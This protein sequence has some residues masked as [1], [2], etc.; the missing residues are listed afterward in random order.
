[1]KQDKPEDVSETVQFYS[2]NEVMEMPAPEWL[3]KNFLTQKS[4][5]LIYGS[6]GVG[7]T[8]LAIDIAIAT[9]KG[10]PWFGNETSSGSVVLISTEGDQGL[11][12]RL[13]GWECEKK[14][15]LEN[16]DNFIVCF[17][18]INFAKE[19]AQQALLKKINELPEQPRLIIID[20]FADCFAQC[21]GNENDSGSVGKFLG[22]VKRIVD[23]T[24][25]TALIVHHTRKGDTSERGST[26]LR[27]AMDSMY[28]VKSTKSELYMIASTKQRNFA[29]PA[30]L[31][32]LLKEVTLPKSEKAFALSTTCIPER[33]DMSGS[34]GIRRAAAS[35]TRNQKIVLELLAKNDSLRQVDI[36]KITG[37]SKSSA[38][39]T[40]KKLEEYHL[41]GNDN[42]NYCLAPDVSKCARVFGSGDNKNPPEPNTIDAE[43]LADLLKPDF[44]EEATA[45]DSSADYEPCCDDWDCDPNDFEDPEDDGEPF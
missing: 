10:L 3:I 31:Y 33:V 16:T 29:A 1:M 27:A 38:S 39:E 8:F 14:I 9:A 19:S 44:D 23:Q 2:V 30:N 42:G 32:Y 6:P 11:Q 45:F 35:L 18:P 24:G 4:M 40:M 34:L 28:S 25:A 22:G 20:T 21:D 7:K 12:L 13:R 41:V 17:Q 37:L 5:V 26:V 43:D 36:R 15:N